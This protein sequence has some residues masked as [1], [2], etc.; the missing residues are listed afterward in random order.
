MKLRVTR[1]VKGFTLVEVMVVVLTLAIVTAAV[2]TGFVTLLTAGQRIRAAH[3]INA[4]ASRAIRMVSDD[5]RSASRVDAVGAGSIVLAGPDAQVGPI[6]YELAG[7][8][9][10]RSGPEGRRT[11][12]KGVVSVGFVPLTAAGGTG[13]DVG[14]R[15][16]GT[17]LELVEKWKGGSVTGIFSVVTAMRNGGGR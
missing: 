5:V 15:M 2:L 11:V 16:V 13:D 9:L 3:S 6:R 4:T 14:A 7:G 12:C 17:R 10:T 1:R 8:A